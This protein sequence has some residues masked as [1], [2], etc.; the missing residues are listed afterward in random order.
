MRDVGREGLDRL[1]AVVERVG[2]VAQ[3]TGQVAD[4]IA[5]AG[6]IGNLNARSDAA[7]NTLRAVGETPHRPRDGAGQQQRQHDHDDHSDTEHFQ[8]RQ[9]L[10]RHHL[11]DVVA[12]RG[13]HQRAENGG[14]RPL[15]RNSDRDDDFAAVVDAH[16]AGLL[17]CERL[18][19]LL[20]TVAILRAEFAVKRKIAAIE[21][22]TDRDSGALHEARLDVGRRWQFEAYDIAAT[23][24]AA[25]V[26]DQYAITV[27]DA[28]TGVGRRDQPPQ[29]GSDALRIDW[30]IQS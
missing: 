8:N 15:H 7:A 30:K 13:Q 22:G 4:F 20:V 5:A 6:K 16:H 1:D 21:P 12:L 11:V 26:E 25:A 14:A 24:K 9:P 3:R 27:I 23:K 29:H 28:R 10:S 2:H 18:R 17:T 19:D